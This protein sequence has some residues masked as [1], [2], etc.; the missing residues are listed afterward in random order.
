MKA[1]IA[2]LGSSFEKFCF[3]RNFN[4][5]K[6]FFFSIEIFGYI[7]FNI[8]SVFKEPKKIVWKLELLGFGDQREAKH[9]PFVY[10]ASWIKTK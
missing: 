7:F 8:F 10:K 9:L 3:L 2:D 1:I 4:S 6:R 5:E